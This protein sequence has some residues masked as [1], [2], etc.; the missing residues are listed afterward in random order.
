MSK[1][2][3]ERRQFRKALKAGEKLT[4]YQWTRIKKHGKRK[5]RAA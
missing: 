1:H 2:N 5:L 4:P 3:V